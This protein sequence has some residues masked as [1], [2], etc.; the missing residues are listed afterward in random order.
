MEILAILFGVIV[1]LLGVIL[2][3]VMEVLFFG[4]LL[5]TFAYFT[6]K[7]IGVSIILGTAITFGV[8]FKVIVLVT[9][10]IKVISVGVKLIKN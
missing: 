1:T 9:L 4:V 6:L 3:A 2:L 7:I 5:T 8:L 10:I